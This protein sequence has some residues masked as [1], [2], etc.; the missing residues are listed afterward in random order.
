M[1]SP[2]EATPMHTARDWTSP[3][4][5]TLT[6]LT[7]VHSIC[8]LLAVSFQLLN[9]FQL[10]SLYCFFS[11]TSATPAKSPRGNYQRLGKWLGRIAWR[12]MCQCR[13]AMLIWRIWCHIGSLQYRSSMAKNGFKP[14]RSIWWSLLAIRRH[15]E[16]GSVSGWWQ[17]IL[18]WNGWIWM[19]SYGS[20]GRHPFSVMIHSA[21]FNG[22]Y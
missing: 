6:I 5:W 21:V 22:L 3:W 2:M 19:L 20:C 11:F 14:R 7:S 13:E 4:T 15:V 9:R 16:Y 18:L 1:F 12:S 10:L 8:I 17:Y